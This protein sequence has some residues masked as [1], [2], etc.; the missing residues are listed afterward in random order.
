MLQRLLNGDL[1]I[2]AGR[3]SQE[4][5]MVLADRDAASTIREKYCSNDN[6]N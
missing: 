1:S 5:A 4:H 6:I 2:P 3:I